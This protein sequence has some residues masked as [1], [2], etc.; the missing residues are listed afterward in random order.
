MTNEGVFASSSSSS[1]QLLNPVFA[2]PHFQPD[3][4]VEYKCS[5]NSKSKGFNYL[6]ALVL[7]GETRQSELQHFMLQ[8]G[9]EAFRYQAQQQNE[10]GWTALMLAV[11]NSR[12]DST[13]HI[14]EV[15]LPQSDAKQQNK[16]GWTALMHAAR[17]SRND[18]TEHTV[19]L[20]LP[21]SDA[22]Q[23]NKE[24]WTALMFAA[25]GSRE[26]STEHTVQ[27][28]LPLSDAKQQ[29]QHGWTALMMAAR[30]SKTG[31]TERTVEML[32]PFSDV[33]Q[34]DKSG[35]TALKY[36]LDV[37]IAEENEH[38]VCMFITRA[39]KTTIQQCVSAQYAETIAHIMQVILQRQTERET[40]QNAIKNGLTLEESIIKSYI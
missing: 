10:Q 28:L 5:T 21:Y 11:R 37:F 35:N 36:A 4:D 30:W 12:T 15:L 2:Q 40:F 17:Y 8:Q 25:M 22:K 13:D 9:G 16:A 20:L 31:S 7:G 32:L 14:V 38:I 19:E 29:D 3:P 33:D 39:S 6:Q 1:A 23:Q 26:D 18:S 24:G 27:L 34:R